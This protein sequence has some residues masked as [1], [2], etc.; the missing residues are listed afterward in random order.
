MNKSRGIWEKRKVHLIT[1][2]E[3]RQQQELEW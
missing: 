1:Q 3:S 2:V